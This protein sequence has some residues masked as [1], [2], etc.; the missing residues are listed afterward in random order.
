VIRVYD[1]IGQRDRD[2]LASAR[3]QG[4]V[5]VQSKACERLVRQS[6]PPVLTLL[7]AQTPSR[8]IRMR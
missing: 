8:N 4:V 6:T 3:F 2:A 1:E 7:E 5:K